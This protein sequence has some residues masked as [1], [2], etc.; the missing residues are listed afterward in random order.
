MFDSVI[1]STIIVSYE[2][3][4]ILRRTLD[5]CYKGVFF[6]LS[7]FPSWQHVQICRVSTTSEVL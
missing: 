1:N 4:F 2:I 3:G 5:I 6:V 7:K